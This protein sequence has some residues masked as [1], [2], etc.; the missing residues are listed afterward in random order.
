MKDLP[1]FVSHSWSWDE[2]YKEL[3]QRL[4]VLPFKIKDNSVPKERALAILQDQEAKNEMKGLLNERI[5]ILQS[6]LKQRRNMLG[7]ISKS[8]VEYERELSDIELFPNIGKILHDNIFGTRDEELDVKRLYKIK[9]KYAEIDIKRARYDVQ[10]KYGELKDQA[11]AIRMICNQIE[12]TIRNFRDYGIRN[13]ADLAE[14]LGVN[15][16]LSAKLGGINSELQDRLLGES[17]NLLA[18]LGNRI[19]SSR[20]FL[21]L[22]HPDHLYKNWVKFEHEQAY[23]SQAFKVGITLHSESEIP[24]YLKRQYDAVFSLKDPNLIAAIGSI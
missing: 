5:E 19:L 1:V 24:H 3:M 14:V 8:I 10:K 17:R 4:E 9:E 11:L 22:P 12:K 20:V 15:K 2:H 6:D 7:E 13:E 21:A 16:A 23:K 18:A